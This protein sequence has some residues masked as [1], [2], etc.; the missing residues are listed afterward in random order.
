MLPGLRRCVDGAG[1]EDRGTCFS[2]GVG[3]HYD[4]CFWGY[5]FDGAKE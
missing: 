1:E 4:P 3:C 5:H 2:V